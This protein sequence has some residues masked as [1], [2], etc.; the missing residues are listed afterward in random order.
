MTE[1]AI[2]HKD[3]DVRGG[4]EVL[5]EYLADGFDC[6]LYIGHGNPENQPE[7]TDFDI[8]ELAPDSWWHKLMDRGG[9]LRGIGHMMH[10]RDNADP[11][12]DY[13]T[14]ILSGNEPLW[15]MPTDT[16]TVI[17]YTHTPPRYMY[18]LYHTSDG[19]VGRTYQQLQRRLYEGQVR[20]PDLWV[21]NS[22]LVARRINLYWNI[23]KE[24]IQVVYPP[25]PA[26][27]FDHRVRETQDY[28]LYLGRLSRTKRVHELIEVFNARE[29]DTLIIAGDGPEREHLEAQA[30]DGIYFEGYVTE[31]YKKQ[32]LSEAKALLYPPKNEDFGMV[33]IEAMASGTPV[34]GVNEGFTKHQIIHPHNGILYNRSELELQNAI[35]YLDAEGTAMSDAEIAEWTERRFGVDRFHEQMREAV[36]MAHER[37]AVMP[38]WERSPPARM[39]PDGGE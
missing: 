39:E 11:L 16:Q 7:D 37:T 31:A 35:D 26:S 15:W 29:D 20:R 18:D 22:D 21:A 9:A 25:I 10:W 3:Y 27:E 24:Q 32:L 34:I 12:H 6:P 4:G 8:R 30:G 17:A 2:A 33:P 1:I 36:D 14:V 28:Y 5:A 38:E 23:P 19:F 13:E